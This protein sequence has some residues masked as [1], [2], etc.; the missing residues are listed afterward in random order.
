M[1]RVFKV[2]K[3]SE[4]VFMSIIRPRHCCR[5]L[6]A[7]T[8]KVTLFRLQCLKKEDF[9][10]H[11]GFALLTSPLAQILTTQ[12]TALTLQTASRDNRRSLNQSEQSLAELLVVVLGPPRQA[13]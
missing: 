1:L 5:V 2:S 8:P 9:R 3:L 11:L 13:Q 7:H 6:L 4:S 10:K 12:R